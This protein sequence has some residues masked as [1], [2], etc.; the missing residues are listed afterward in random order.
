MQPQPCRSVRKRDVR[1]A[2]SKEFSCRKSRGTRRFKKLFLSAYSC[3][4]RQGRQF[5]CGKFVQDRIQLFRGIHIRIFVM[6]FDCFKIGGTDRPMGNILRSVCLFVRI[7][8]ACIFS[9]CVFPACMFRCL[10]FRLMQFL[11]RTEPLANMSQMF[12]HY[13][14]IQFHDCANFR[15]SAAVSETE[16]IFSRFQYHSRIRG[17]VTCQIR[18][19]KLQRHDLTLSRL[20]AVCFCKCRQLLIFFLNP[21]LRTAYIKLKHFF[22]RVLFPCIFYP[23]RNRDLCMIHKDFFHIP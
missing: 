17:T 11:H 16:P 7:F 20:Q 2:F 22:S 10:P 13:L 4:C 1:N 18:K 12:C 23:D 14:F 8:P 5:L 6:I 15:V 3:A 9:V 21:S 19:I